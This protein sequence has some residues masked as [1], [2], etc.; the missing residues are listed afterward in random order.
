[1]KK[2]LTSTE[3]A[4]VIPKLNKKT[5][6]VGGC[7]DILHIGHINFLQ[8]AKK[9]GEVLLVMLEHDSTIK[10]RK[11]PKRPINTQQ[12]RATILN[13][14]EM[15]DYVILLPEQTDNTFYDE[16]INQLKPAIIATTA[17]DPF[18]N[19]KER[20]AKQI[21]AQVV[22]VIRPVSNKST[23]TLVHLLEEL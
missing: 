17:G 16:L 20:Q 18:R 11:G 8:H 5:V 6:L 3:A 23:T 7:F 19:H 15:V 21:G 9:Q 13:S 22:D 10:K 2:I 1:M 4:E 14:L 12:D